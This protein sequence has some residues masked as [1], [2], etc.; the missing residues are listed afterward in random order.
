M[1]D[2]KVVTL[3]DIADRLGTS[4]NTVSRALRDC[5]DIGAEMKKKVRQTAEEMGYQPNR[6]AG[7]MRTKKS[8]IIAI[9]I[10]S[11]GNPFFS[12]CLD[13][14]FAYLTEK[15]YHPLIVVKRES[16]L[17]VEDI[18]RCVQSGACGIITFVDLETETADFCDQQDIPLL[19]CG[20]QPKD[21][22]VSAVHS[23]DYR[24][25]KLAAQEA[26]S[27]GCT[28]PCYISVRDSALGRL[29]HGRR[30]GFVKILESENISCIDY[31]YDSADQADWAVKV[32]EEILKNRNDFIF[33]FNDVIAAVISE[34]L[35]DREEFKGR[36]YG[37]DGVS[38]YLPY[39]KQ[40][41]SVGGDL[42]KISV[43]CCRILLNRIV[44]ED[45]KIVR[46][47]FPTELIR[48]NY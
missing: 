25:G 24:C 35:S 33:C 45:R 3:S 6:I 11:L 42:K 20:L 14:I 21:E 22:R 36:I 34:A 8:N 28:N 31:T 17:R 16:E 1:R 23:D 48:F 19:V 41:N 2:L 43:R 4:K 26:I 27:L 7:F 12:I 29:N 13:Y 18:I 38:R 32:K 39:S 40:V 44:N 5:S 15:D 47:I 46:E 9:V 10:S 37:V 30:N